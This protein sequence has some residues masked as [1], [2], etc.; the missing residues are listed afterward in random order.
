MAIK[1]GER[2]GGVGRTLR[3]AGGRVGRFGRRLGSGLPLAA[4]SA[5]AAVVL[6]LILYSVASNDRPTLR[7]YA[8]FTMFRNGCAVEPRASLNASRCLRLGQGTYVV[9][10]ERSLRNGTVVA[11]RGSC[12]PG[13]IAASVTTERT[14]AVL[15]ERRVRRPIRATVLIP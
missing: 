8:E 3:T 12:C 6:A 10:F 2:I 13:S 1:L 14:V 4:V 11:S 7:A 9:V 5:L 15:V